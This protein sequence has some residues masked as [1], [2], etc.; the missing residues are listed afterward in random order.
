M[1]SETWKKS[2][3]SSLIDF[4]KPWPFVRE[5]A[6]TVPSSNSASSIF[7]PN[8]NNF[9][10]KIYLSD[11]SCSRSPCGESFRCHSYSGNVEWR[12]RWVLVNYQNI[13][14]IQRVSLTSLGQIERLWR[15]FYRLWHSKKSQTYFCLES[16]SPSATIKNSDG[17]NSLTSSNHY[18]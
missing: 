15:Y 9:N 16:L 2:A 17:Q 5:N 1:T 4:R 3:S 18:R 11:R 8:F 14:Y 6:K 13:T 12:A 7:Y 10:E